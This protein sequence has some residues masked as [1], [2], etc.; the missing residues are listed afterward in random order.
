MQQRRRCGSGVVKTCWCNLL[1]LLLCWRCRRQ[2][3]LLLLLWL[4][5]HLRCTRV[6]TGLSPLSAAL[7]LLLGALQLCTP[8]ASSTPRSSTTQNWLAAV[9]SSTT[10]ARPQRPSAS[11]W[12]CTSDP[13]STKKA[14]AASTQRTD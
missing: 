13:I 14:A 7:L 11:T 1:L 5:L 4:M 2:Q 6:V 8:T 12:P 3:L 9:D 10:A